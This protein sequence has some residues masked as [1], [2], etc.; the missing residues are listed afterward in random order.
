MSP[1]GRLPPS[2]QFLF[3][4]SLPSPGLSGNLPF[5]A[6]TEQQPGAGAY[7]ENRPQT[8]VHNTTPNPHGNA[9]A[10][11]AGYTLCYGQ[12]GCRSFLHLLT[13][14]LWTK[15]CPSSSTMAIENGFTSP[16]NATIYV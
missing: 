12:K 5:T 11:D 2:S 10:P 15:R 14:I 6:R 9:S 13:V 16:V 3:G 8:A 4:I 1:Q 7:G